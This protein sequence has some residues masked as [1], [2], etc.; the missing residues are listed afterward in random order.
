MFDS[1]S[2]FFI[3]DQK[4]EIM[5]LH[6]LG[7]EDRMRS[8]QNV[9]LPCLEFFESLLLFSSRPKSANHVDCRQK[10]RKPLA[11]RL[12]MLLRQNG[13]RHQHRRLLAVH[14]RLVRRAD[15]NF[16]FAEAHVA[17]HQS[18]HRLIA[19]HVRLDLFDRA[20]LICRF[21]VC[22]CLFKILLRRVVI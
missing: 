3:D 1:E 10:A 12:K 7:V 21:L 15:C 11:E 18:I 5:K 16:R 8:D 4:T 20:E 9:D 13:R 14:C 22:K 2:L 19:F 17:A 6:A